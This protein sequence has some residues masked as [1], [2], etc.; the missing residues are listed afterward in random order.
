M[1]KITSL[2]LLVCGVILIIWGINAS[3]SLGSDFTRFFTGNA[4]DKSMWLL[5]SGT[6]AAVLG[7][8]GMLF[9]GR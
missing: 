5:V 3:N 1:N 2:A 8:S 6:A 4:T 9:L 7:A